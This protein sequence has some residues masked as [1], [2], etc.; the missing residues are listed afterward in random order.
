MMTVKRALIGLEI[1]TLCFGL[2]ALGAGC[3][4]GSTDSSGGMSVEDQVKK[5][6][7]AKAAMEAAGKAQKQA[8][9]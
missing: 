3:G 2:T 4:G 9:K 7:D 5:T 6:Q 1:L 8:K